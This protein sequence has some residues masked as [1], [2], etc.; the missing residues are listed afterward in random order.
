MET[1]I[2]PLTGSRIKVL[3]P[4][5]RNAVDWLGPWVNTK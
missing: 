2:A 5:I 4:A 1:Q 3:E